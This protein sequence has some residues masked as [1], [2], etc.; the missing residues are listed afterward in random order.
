PVPFVKVC[1]PSYRYPV[2]DE[3][4]HANVPAILQHHSPVRDDLS[5][6]DGCRTVLHHHSGLRPTPLSQ[7]THLL[8]KHLRRMDGRHVHLRRVYSCH[9]V[10]RPPLAARTG[11]PLEPCGPSLRL[12]RDFLNALG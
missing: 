2:Q 10:A 6:L 7:R 11:P 1:C 4:R 12:L 8:A 9:A 5:R 3:W